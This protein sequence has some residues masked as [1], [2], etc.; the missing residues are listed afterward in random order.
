MEKDSN[1]ISAKFSS[2]EI[3]HPLS[4]ILN[5]IQKYKQT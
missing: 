1:N 4:C 5:V 2:E 3:L